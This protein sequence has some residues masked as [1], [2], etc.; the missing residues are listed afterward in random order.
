VGKSTARVLII[1]EFF[2]GKGRST[3]SSNYWLGFKGV[4]G[5]GC[6]VLKRS[7]KTKGG[8]DRVGWVRWETCVSLDDQ[9]GGLGRGIKI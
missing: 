3:G 1:Q 6:R 4:V 5:R 8:E 9:G 7:R 2:R